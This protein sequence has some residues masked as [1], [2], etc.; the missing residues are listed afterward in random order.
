[1]FDPNAW[2]VE[3]NGL[4]GNYLIR[5]NGQIWKSGLT[6]QGVCALVSDRRLQVL[7]IRTGCE[8]ELNRQADLELKR[9]DYRFDTKEQR[10]VKRNVAPE[11]E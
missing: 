4:I 8:S 5:H 1:M 11:K 6:A 7:S 9:R 3:T 2:G 10:W